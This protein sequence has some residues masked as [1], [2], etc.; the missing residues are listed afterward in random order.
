MFERFWQADS[1]AHARATAASAS[2]CRWCGTSS[3]CTAATSRRTARGPARARASDRA[4]AQR[5]RQGKKAGSRTPPCVIAG[6]RTLTCRP[7]SSLTSASELWLTRM[8]VTPSVES[9]LPAPVTSAFAALQTEVPLTVHSTLSPRTRSATSCFTGASA[10][11]PWLDGVV[12]RRLLHDRER[13]A[14]AEAADDVVAVA[15]RRAVERL[16]R[17]AVEPLAADEHAVR[18]W[19]VVRLLRLVE[20]RLDADSHPCPRSPGSSRARPRRSSS[21][22]PLPSGASFES[23]IVRS[24]RLPGSTR[25]CHPLTVTPPPAT[26]LSASCCGRAPAGPSSHKS[27]APRHLQELKL[28]P[29]ALLSSFRR[30]RRL[31]S[32][33]PAAVVD[34]GRYSTA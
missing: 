10:T 33:L 28:S 24:C 7:R 17:I 11:R 21:A 2:G 8:P 19:M 25:P 9:S 14:A 26:F 12:R 4:A 22:S 3:S 5:A 23:L 18:M 13:L 1:D 32:R 34:V 15:V 20:R 16:R 27:A 31:K 6:R 30:T 29:D